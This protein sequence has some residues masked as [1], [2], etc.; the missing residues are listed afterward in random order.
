MNMS[1]MPSINKKL[2]VFVVFV[3]IVII[4]LS[5]FGSLVASWGAG[6]VGVL[7]DPFTGAV[8]NLGVGPKF[9]IKAPWQ[10][11]ITVPVSIQS[12]DMWTD[13]TG[14][15]GEW[16]GVTVYTSDGLQAVVDITVQ[17]AIRPEYAHEVYKAYPNFDWE[18]KTFAP[19]LRQVVRDIIAEYKG[20]ETIPKRGEIASRIQEEFL[21]RLPGDVKSW[22]IIKSVNLRNIRLPTAYIQ[23]IEQKLAAE[24]AKLKAEYEKERMRIEAEAQALK[25]KLEAEG[26][27][28]ATIIEAEGRAQAILIEA[29]ARAQAK[30]LE[31][32][33]EAQAKMILANA[34]KY[35][36]QIIAEAFGNDPRLALEYLKWLYWTQALYN[37][38]LIWIGGGNTTAVPVIPLKG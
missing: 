5:M 30:L 25:A 34:T 6:E 29:Q 13:E 17:Y 1:K 19:T 14:R 35:Q 26:K 22:F 21:N 24:Q 3:I 33:A 23:A 15:Q 37:A 27:R 20:I 2:S 12:L 16:P 8:T 9:V 10:T 32:Q 28:N 31:A 4:L 18:V 36:I 11:L 7:L 38:T